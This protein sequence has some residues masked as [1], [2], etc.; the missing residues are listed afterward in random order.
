M[1]D[2]IQE[3][4]LDQRDLRA[5]KDMDKLMEERLH[6]LVWKA[7]YGDLIAPVTHLI[8]Q[9]KVLCNKSMPQPERNI[10]HLAGQ[11][12]TMLKIRIS[13]PKS[14]APEPQTPPAD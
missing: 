7:V 11:L 1:R 9:A 8:A 5:V 3:E 14:P 6:K 13:Q 4:L 10:N 2:T 12:I